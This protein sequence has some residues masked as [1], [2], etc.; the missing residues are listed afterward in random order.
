MT[1]LHSSKSRAWT[2]VRAP[3][4]VSTVA[5][6]LGAA[7]VAPMTL[8]E[9]QAESS[10][11]V[12]PERLYQE[13]VPNVDPTDD[14]ILTDIPVEKLPDP[15]PEPPKEEEVTAAAPA[16]PAGPPRYTGGGSPAEWMAAAGIAESD[17]GYVDYIVSRESTWNPNAINPSGGYCGLVQIAPLHGVENCTD[18]VVNLT[19]ATSYA[20]GRYGSWEGAYNH[21]ATYQSGW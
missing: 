21:W 10:A 19:W 6:F 5:V 4:A 18:P 15:K 2:K 9:A 11:A 17:W 16:V 14:L 13:F 20:V 7:V 8:P 12:V 1:A 3:L